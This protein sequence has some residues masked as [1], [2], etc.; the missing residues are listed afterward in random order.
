MSHDGAAR[1]SN[2]PHFS[3]IDHH[4]S[5][6]LKVLENVACKHSVDSTIFCRQSW[7][8]PDEPGADLIGGAHLAGKAQHVGGH[9]AG[10]DVSE[11]FR[12]SER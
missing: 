9:I 8:D 11:L 10:D 5:E 4:L 2:P 1:S 7:G 12:S 6:V 3:E